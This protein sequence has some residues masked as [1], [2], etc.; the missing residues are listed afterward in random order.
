MIINQNNKVI[1][2]AN[3]KVIINDPVNEFLGTVSTDWGNA[4]NWS[5]GVIPT[6][7]H[8]AIIRANCNVGLTRV[9]RK[10]DIKEGVTLTVNSSSALDIVEEITGTDKTAKFVVA[11]TG[12]VYA[13]DFTNIHVTINTNSNVV[14][15]NNSGL[16]NYNGFD[17]TPLGAYSLRFSN[18]SNVKILVDVNLNTGG[19]TLSF[20]T[21]DFLNSNLAV[22][23]L[24]SDGSML[25]RTGQGSITANSI[26]SYNYATN[27]YFQNVA[28]VSAINLIGGAVHW[29]NTIF[30][31]SGA[32]LVFKTANSQLRGFGL[33]TLYHLLKIDGVTVTLESGQ[34]LIIHQ[35]KFTTVNGGQ[36][37]ALGRIFII[38]TAFPLSQNV[39]HTN[40]QA[41]CLTSN[42][43][44]DDIVIN[45]SYIKN[46]L[47]TGI[48]EKKLTANLTIETLAAIVNVNGS[49]AQYQTNVLNLTSYNLTVNGVTSNSGLSIKRTSDGYITF[50]G[51]YNGYSYNGGFNFSG[52]T[53]AN[54]LEFQN[55][56]TLTHTYFNVGDTTFKITTNNQNF[57]VSDNRLIKNLVV[58][59]VVCYLYHANTN[60]SIQLGDVQ[61]INGGSIS[62]RS[63]RVGAMYLTLLDYTHVNFQNL[64]IPQVLYN[65][66]N[67]NVLAG[68]Y[69]QLQ[70]LGSGTKTLLGNV[71]VTG[72]YLKQSTVT[73]NKNGFTIKDSL[74]NDLA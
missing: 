26:N 27:T 48:G 69:N 2:N 28:A 50:K 11:T 71:V 61:T 59:G 16:L 15:R 33:N 65:G 66:A 63:D 4:V 49:T 6:A 10:V 34:D 7:N 24:S 53:S 17:V 55:G 64:H 9:A 19:F 36:L 37:V 21:I 46:L 57:G 45:T 70:L 54:V 44:A 68:T 13:K 12:Q 32:D 38:A 58:D 41:V 20:T 1:I 23:T 14:F 51:Q 31:L 52:V 42:S 67:Q 22:G 25:Y 74:G 5:L 62:F 40:S 18:C 72:T 3:G 47:L 56:S 73:L 60:F 30:D 8:L 35:T 39:D 29:L 43:N